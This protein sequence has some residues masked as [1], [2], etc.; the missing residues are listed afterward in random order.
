LTDSE[1]RDSEAYLSFGLVIGED[2]SSLARRQLNAAAESRI[3][4][5]WVKWPVHGCLQVFLLGLGLGDLPFRID[6]LIDEES[7]DEIV[8]N[9]GGDAVV[10][11]SEISVGELLDNPLL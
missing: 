10:L 11:E 4:Q 5:G 6:I 1:V 2:P 9:A 8:T 3:Y 7:E